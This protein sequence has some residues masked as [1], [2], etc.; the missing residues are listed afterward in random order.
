MAFAVKAQPPVK[1]VTIMGHVTGDNKGYDKIYYYTNAAQ[2]DS[3][4]IKDHAFKITLPFKSTYNQI[5]F[6]DY[7]RKVT[8]RNRLFPLL[9]RRPG[10]LQLE[11]DI[12]SGLYAAT[13]TGNKST[14]LF[15]EFNHRE[16]KIGKDVLSQIH[17]IHSAH[18]EWKL[19]KLQYK[20][21]WDSLATGPTGKVV[22]DI[23]SAHPDD[24]A[25][26]FILQMSKSILPL[27]VIR[28]CLEK[29]SPN[30]RQTHGAKAMR[31][32]L[33]ARGKVKTGDKAPA[34]ELADLHQHFFD[35]NKQKGKY[36]L[37]DFWVSW[38][39]PCK[40]AFPFLQK[41]YAQ[42]KEQNFEI[43]DISMDSKT[44]WKNREKVMHNPWPQLW[45]NKLVATRYAVTSPSTFIL[46]DPNGKILLKET[47]LEKN[48]AI[49]RKLAGFFKNNKIN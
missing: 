43:V 32:Y 46:I 23:I 20:A 8:G 3:V 12:D 36:V 48:G 35:F 40:T 25:S 15:N 16:E 5:L 33:N 4:S 22:S 49:D 45:D 38:Y 47:T 10:V 29:L 31:L 14:E 17:Q 26:V 2:F 30:L 39:E 42:Y 1:T 13:I 24:F 27:S 41:L 7:E 37:L 6:T 44:A 11:M 34:F 21:L 18:T 28:T 9:I 19:S